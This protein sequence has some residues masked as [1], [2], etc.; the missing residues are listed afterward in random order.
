MGPGIISNVSLMQWVINSQHFRATNS[1]LSIP[2][3][4]FLLDV[5]LQISFPSSSGQTSSP[6][7]YFQH[8]LDRDGCRNSREDS[9]SG[10][11]PTLNKPRRDRRSS[12]MFERR[13]L[14]GRPCRE[15]CESSTIS[16]PGR[17]CYDAEWD[18]EGCF[19]RKGP[20]FYS[21]FSRLLA[22]WR[23]DRDSRG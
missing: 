13:P 21:G 1:Q 16:H 20:V 3:V 4:N 15:R 10:T 9:W 6:L 22:F 19:R 8:S 7:S 2:F 17:S 23:K 14:D 18:L 11:V 12:W 5:I